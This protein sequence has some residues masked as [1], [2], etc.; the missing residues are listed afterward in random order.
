MNISVSIHR[1]GLGQF[2]NGFANSTTVREGLPQI[3]VCNQQVGV[4]RKGL[5]E[6]GNGLPET[7]KANIDIAEFEVSLRILGIQL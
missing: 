1:L 7:V 3:G 2:G 6:I 4:L 5:P